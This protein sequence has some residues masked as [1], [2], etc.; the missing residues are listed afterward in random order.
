M[1]AGRPRSSN[2]VQAF[3][4][5]LDQGVID[6]EWL[7]GYTAGALDPVTV[8]GHVY[9]VRDNLAP[10]VFW[11]NKALFD[12]FGYDIP[13]TW[14][15]YE[16]L[17]EKLAAEH[18]GYIL[19]SIGDPFTAVL[20]NM[21]SAQAPIYTVDGDTFSA[22]F[23]DDHTTRMIDLMDNM[24]ANGSLAID[25]LFTPDFPA[26]YKDKVLGIPGPTWFTGA[27]IQNPDILAAAGRH[28]GRRLPA[29]LGGRGH[30]H[31]QRRWRHLVRLEPLDE[32]RR[33][34]HVPAVRDERTEVG[35]TDHRSPGLRVHRERLVGRAG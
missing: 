1:P 24:F 8:D 21:W 5:A 9:G 17:G 20:T 15:D 34:R 2:G 22:D 16:A 28:V 29:A 14:E 31:R 25:G 30:R 23:A 27:I 35:R 26:K 13:E 32:P 19:G 11:Y 3:A 10:V 33:R 6:Q 18:P 12:E 7:D 4:A